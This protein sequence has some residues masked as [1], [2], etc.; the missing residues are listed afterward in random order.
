M[1]EPATPEIRESASIEALA[2]E[3]AAAEYAG[4]SD[5]GEGAPTVV[6][7]EAAAVD[8]SD[9]P[10]DAPPAVESQGQ[11]EEPPAA[12]SAASGGDS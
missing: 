11:N 5:L 12:A 6:Q 1:L 3:F 2:V 4:E 7:A 8:L 10:S 9:A